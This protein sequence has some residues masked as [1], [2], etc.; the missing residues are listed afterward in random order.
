M[1]RSPSSGKHL[2]PRPGKS[3]TTIT[4]QET[5]GHVRWDA[6]STLLSTKSLRLKIGGL[7]FGSNNADGEKRW[8]NRMKNHILAVL[9]LTGRHTNSY[10]LFRLPVRSLLRCCWMWHVHFIIKNFTTLMV[11]FG[12]ITSDDTLTLIRESTFQSH[13]VFLIML[14]TPF[15]WDVPWQSARW[16]VVSPA[17]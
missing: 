12:P 14:L 13:F 9:F 15:I 16:M 7:H 1:S 5:L 11:F 4:I 8:K 3:T 6:V 10:T 17:F 2:F